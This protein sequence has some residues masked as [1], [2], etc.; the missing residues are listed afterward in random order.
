EAIRTV[1]NSVGC[2]LGGAGHPVCVQVAGFTGPLSGSPVATVLGRSHRTDA[3]RAALLN[4]LAGSVHAF[5]DTHAHSI[6][7][8]GTPVTMAALAAAEA[9]GRRPAGAELLNAAAWG[10]EITCRISRAISAGMPMAVSQ[11]GTAG[12][13]GAAVAAGLVL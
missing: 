12:T 6:V 9:S 2:A 8:P 7:H 11:T 3:S 5:D 1:L 4:G 10:V 13:I